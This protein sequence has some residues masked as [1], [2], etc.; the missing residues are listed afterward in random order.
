[1]NL[2]GSQNIALEMFD[3]SDLMVVVDLSFESSHGSFD[4][5]QGW[6]GR[7]AEPHGFGDSP[8]PM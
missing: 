3:R 8:A 7:S 6:I 2:M 1:M 5:N 4:L